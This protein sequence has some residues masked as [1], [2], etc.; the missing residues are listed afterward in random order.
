MQTANVMAAAPVRGE[1]TAASAN[2]PRDRLGLIS[3][4][5]RSISLARDCDCI[6]G[7]GTAIARND[8]M[9]FTDPATSM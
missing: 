3:G 8:N 9:M 2:Q 7:H 6:S 5:F 1:E 4:M